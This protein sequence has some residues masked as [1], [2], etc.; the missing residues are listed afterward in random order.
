MSTTEFL[1]TSTLLLA[2]VQVQDLSLS[3]EP[4]FDR[5]ARV[6][7]EALR[8]AAA[9]IAVARDDSFWFKAI[10]GWDIDELPGKRSLCQL[11][12]DKK[13]LVVVPDLL[14]DHALREHP[15]AT[16]PPH[17]RFYAGYPLRGAD[18]RFVATL[19]AYDIRP[20]TLSQTQM[21]VLRDLGAMAQKELLSGATRDA[22]RKLVTK[23]GDARR[24]AMI[25]ALTR[26]WNRRAG[27]QLLEEACSNV[28]DDASIAVAMVDVDHLKGVNEEHGRQAGDEILRK[29]VR[30]MVSAVRDGDV[31]SRYG[32]DGFMLVLRGLTTD[33][34]DRLVERIRQ[35]V[36]ESPIRTR[37]GEIGISVSA[38]IAMAEPGRLRESD[39]LVRLADEALLRAKTE[40]SGQA[41]EA[42][43][44]RP[45]TKARR[46]KNVP[47]V[48][49]ER[50]YHRLQPLKEQPAAADGNRCDG[51][52]PYDASLLR[53][54]A[55]D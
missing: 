22:Q 54:F 42:M 29:V 26:V 53:G 11:A 18:G 2:G 5:L 19:C 27:L 50:T 14:E 52:N 25:D 35:R 46:R 20:R 8:V 12:M 45:A 28:R 4:R 47:A 36:S 32:D 37:A 15:L 7:R 39:V 16:K 6:T 17:I 38:G 44:P 10:A 1:N 41:A 9:G 48:R 13:D 30:L 33:E 31:I 34:V 23:L 43:D 51:E 3:L 21:Q 49:E 55:W 40:G 24:D